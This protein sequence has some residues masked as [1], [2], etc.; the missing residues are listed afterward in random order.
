MEEWG[1]PRHL[2]IQN[3]VIHQQFQSFST[4]TFSS[5][6]S[7]PPFFLGH[8]GDNIVLHHHHH[9]HHRHPLQLNTPVIEP[10]HSMAF[11]TKSTSISIF[12]GEHCD[13]IDLQRRKKPARKD[14]HSK[15]FTA[16]GPRD[17]RVRLSIDIARKF[18][19]LQHLLG[20]DK[21]SNTLD[22]LLNKSNTAIK[23][24]A[25]TKQLHRC[26]GAPAKSF[27]CT[28]ECEVASGTIEAAKNGDSQGT[29]M[30]KEPLTS[31][32]KEKKM[33]EQHK[34]PLH[35]LAREA[36]AKARARARERTREKWRSR[37]L[38]DLKK[39]PDSSAFIHHQSRSETTQA[40]TWEKLGFHNE[41]SSLKGD[42]NPHHHLLVNEAASKDD[43]EQSIIIRK[44]MKPSPTLHFQQNLINLED[45]TAAC[46]NSYFPPT[47]NE[48]DQ[49]ISSTT[50]G[51]SF[52][53]MTSV[54]PSTGIE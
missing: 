41:F 34:S 45:E 44:K 30:K 24:L 36:R 27:S 42:L 15:I 40:E 46:S 28:S 31:D 49:E 29:I 32:R 51:S 52:S 8:D 4:V 50:T 7:S 14:R 23:E 3:A 38:N 10:V 5:F 21:A 19:D 47:T 37:Q 43:I 9:H 13:I 16:Q 48:H 25:Q 2:L 18:F 22:W 17:R 20:C 35:L 6:H 53:A 33:T 1:C 26:S 54:Y 12:N 11:S 39:L